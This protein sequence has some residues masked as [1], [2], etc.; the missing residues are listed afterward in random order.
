MNAPL[1]NG[2]DLNV[3]FMI[4]FVAEENADFAHSSE[5]PP[6]FYMYMM[7]ELL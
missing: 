2:R 6:Y 5:K 4:S 7:E 3:A 1:W